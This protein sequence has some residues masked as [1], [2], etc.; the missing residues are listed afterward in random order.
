MIEELKQLLTMIE[1]MPEMVLHVLLGFGVYKLV[2]FLGTSAGIY[3]TIRLAINKLYDW[4]TIEHTK[5]RVIEYKFGEMFVQ[6]LDADRLMGEIKSTVP[7]NL[8]YIHS[9]HVDWI[10]TAIREKK[11][12]EGKK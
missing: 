3:G 2:I 8:S 4:K 5:P 1:K 11:E 10:V 12:R 6:K 9:S 7:S